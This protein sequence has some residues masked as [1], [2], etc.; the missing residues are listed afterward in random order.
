MARGRIGMMSA[1]IAHGLAW[2][3]LLYLVFWPCVY[4]RTTATLALIAVAIDGPRK[5]R[6]SPET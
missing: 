5:P 2:A 1:G 4:M 3:T 6:V